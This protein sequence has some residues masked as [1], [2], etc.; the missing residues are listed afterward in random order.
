MQSGKETLEKSVSER[1]K[2]KD[3]DGNFEEHM[4]NECGEQWDMTDVD[5]RNV[6]TYCIPILIKCIPGINLYG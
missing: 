4:K 6:F 5:A 2:G 1:T 3:S